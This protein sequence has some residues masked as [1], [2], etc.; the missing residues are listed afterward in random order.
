MPRIRQ[1]GKV[2]RLQQA[3]AAQ[4]RASHAL[5]AAVRLDF[6]RGITTFRDNIK[7]GDIVKALFSGKV[8]TV[9]KTLPWNKLGKQLGASVDGIG[10]AAQ[11]AAES[12][13]KLLPKPLGLNYDVR[14]PRLDKYLTQ[15][16]GEMIT[17]VQEGTLQAVRDSTKRAFTSGLT[18]RDVA[19]EIR[20]S[21]GLNARQARALTN[22]RD[23]L[24]KS[25]TAPGRIDSLAEAYGERLLDQRAIMIGRTEVANAI[26]EG[27]Q[28][29]WDTAKEEGLLP[30]SAKRVWIVDG[31]PC[32]QLCLP[33]SMVAV[34]I[35][36]PWTLPDGRKVETPSY[37]H[38]H[39]MCL[40]QLDIGGA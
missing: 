2:N 26:N 22:Y 20:G 8:E 17:V 32:P 33:M 21:I 28:S 19:A 36:E 6:M 18:P 23:N 34:G 27:Q 38:P 15:R 12:A 1:P 40:A 39:C 29:V 31:D 25:G 13:D 37:S 24:E 30:D 35:D 7:L 5:G 14:N 11:R 3:F 4:H 9:F 16:T 10:I